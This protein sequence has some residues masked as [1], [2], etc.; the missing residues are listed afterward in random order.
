MPHT[1]CPNEMYN[2]RHAHLTDVRAEYDTTKVRNMHSRMINWSDFEKWYKFITN[3][4]SG[5]RKSTFRCFEQKTK[6]KTMQKYFTF[7]IWL[8]HH[9]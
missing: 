2:E 6:S 1:K 8:L 4:G 7:R 3:N 9:L 5:V